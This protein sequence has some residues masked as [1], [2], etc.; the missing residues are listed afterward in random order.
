MDCRKILILVFIF[1]GSIQAFPQTDENV[2]RNTSVV[3]AKLNSES[4]MDE[5]INFNTN[6]KFRLGELPGF[7]V[8][9]YNDDNWRTLDVPHDWSVEGK[10]DEKNPSGPNGGFLPTG[11]GCYRKH[12]IM[13]EGCCE[14]D[15][16][17]SGDFFP[18]ANGLLL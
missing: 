3:K 1:L 11:I 7:Y 18:R 4:I 10:F 13:P 9:G 12:F 5:D 8:P 6:W 16:H 17:C 15:R 14:A 2:F